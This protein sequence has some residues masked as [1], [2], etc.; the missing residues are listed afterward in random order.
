MSC[1]LQD[2]EATA[3]LTFSRLL[4]PILESLPRLQGCQGCTAWDMGGW[5]KVALAEHFYFFATDY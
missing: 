2:L 4:L 5:N 1:E 3:A